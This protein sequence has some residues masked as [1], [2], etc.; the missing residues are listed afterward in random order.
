MRTIMV[1]TLAAAALLAASAGAAQAQDGFAL[2]G[3]YLFNESKVDGANDIPEA[4]GFQLG[5]EYVLPMGLGVGLSGYTTGKATE[6]DLR[7]RA[8][9]FLAEANY[10]IKVPVLPIRPY[11][12][13]HAGLGRFKVEDIDDEAEL[14]DSRSEL[15]FQA[16]ARIQLTKLI[17]VDAQY[18]RVSQSAYEDQGD[19]LERNQVLVGVTLF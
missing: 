3:H 15:G 11:V 19:R 14:K 1:R 6:G 8:Y 5:A 9:G 13:V 12:G 4:D 17:G 10:F 2:K 16:G 18:R 7:N